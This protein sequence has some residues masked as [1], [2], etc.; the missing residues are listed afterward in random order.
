MIDRPVR[1]SPDERLTEGPCPG[2]CRAIN[3]KSENCLCRPTLKT[4]MSRSSQG[5][6]PSNNGSGSRKIWACLL[7]NE[8][9][10]RGALTLYYSL[11]KSGTKYPFYI[12]YTDVFVFDGVAKD[13]PYNR[14][15]STFLR[16]ET[17]PLFRYP[18]FGL[19]LLIR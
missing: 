16:R 10:L 5:L 19:L 14:E 6:Y 15:H 8:G 9:Y 4:I 2:A 3:F 18:S 12:I 13:R 7:T 11:I 17:F 1:T